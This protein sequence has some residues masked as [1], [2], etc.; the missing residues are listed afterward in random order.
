MLH[1]SLFLLQQLATLKRMLDSELEVYPGLG[2]QTIFVLVKVG[3][4]RMVC[5][6]TGAVLGLICAGPGGYV[7]TLL[8]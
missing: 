5:S 8:G 6:C 4:V 3:P 7:S 1:I 2:A